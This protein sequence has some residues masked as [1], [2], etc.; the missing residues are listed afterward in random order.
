MKRIDDAKFRR[1]LKALKGS[2][3]NL[4]ELDRSTRIELL[5]ARREFAAKLE[6]LLPDR[7]E[8][9]KIDRIL[10]QSQARQLQILRKRTREMARAQSALDGRSSSRATNRRTALRVL[11][12]PGMA[13]PPSYISLDPFLIWARP[14]NMLFDSRIGPS[15]SWAKISLEDSIES[16]PGIPDFSFGF[17]DLTFYYLW[18]NPSAY[19]AVVNARCDLAFRGS[20]QAVGDSGFL[21]G[22]NA[23]LD[24]YGVL[25][26]L[27]WWNQPPTYGDGN[28]LN[29]FMDLEGDGS[30]FWRFETGD[31][32]FKN[33]FDPIDLRYDLFAIPPKGSAVFEVTVA[34]DYSL[35]NGGDVVIDFATLANYAVTCSSFQLE[36]LTAPVGPLD[37]TLENP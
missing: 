5:R 22:G 29:F 33:Q 8:L 16:F 25:R 15:S 21:L 26:A 19:H 12:T 20:C 14:A 11:S 31:V 23:K 18:S 34:F 4:H 24:G 36:L 6:A 17:A 7:G 9:E 1:A 32:D 13:F 27:E 3:P 28:E 37:A 35:F 30:G 10:K 2:Q